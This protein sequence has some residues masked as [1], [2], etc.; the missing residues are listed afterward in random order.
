M[1]GYEKLIFY[2]TNPLENL[3]TP[4]KKVIIYPLIKNRGFT[5]I[6]L[7][8]VISIISFLSSIVLASLN[9][10][11][12]KAQTAKAKEDMQQIMNAISVAEQDSG[13]TLMG[14]TGSNCS[15]CNCRDVNLRNI[16]STNSCYQAW[17]NAITKIEAAT[18]G[19]YKG[20]SN[21][22]RDPWGSPYLLDE[23][24]GEYGGCGQ[25]NFRSVGPTGSTPPY[26][27]TNV[28]P[29]GVRIFLPY[30]GNSSCR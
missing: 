8:V 13:K 26:D 16:D 19:I 11:R 24:E 15:D 18:N 5:L 1:H 7:L 6:E 28:Y 23:N 12:N 4:M 21:I 17:F 14:I 9:T 22:T 29:D 25:D 27:S 30:S 20:I 3:Y 2:P 10:A